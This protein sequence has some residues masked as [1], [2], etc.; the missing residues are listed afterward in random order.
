V[1]DI[2]HPGRRNRGAGPGS[3]FIL[4][5]LCSF[6]FGALGHD[7][8][9]PNRVDISQALT[10]SGQPTKAFLETLKSQGFEVVIYLAPPTVM[11]AVAEEPKIVGRQGIVFVNIP[12]DF[13]NPTA[14][15]FDAFTKVMRAFEGRKVFVHCQMNF[16]ASS[17]VFL[18]RVV[19]LKEPPGPA[20]QAVQKA[21]VPD[22]VWKKYIVETLRANK[23][24]FEP[25]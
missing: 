17:M 3:K 11:D 7:G 12:M 22:G 16:R 9:A 8:P 23:V 6:A 4:A 2:R 1:N 21:W 25:L 19:T 13:S 18:H 10:T 15:D 5:A 14:A 20:W 24:E